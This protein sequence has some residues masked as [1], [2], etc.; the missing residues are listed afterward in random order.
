MSARILI[1][2]DEVLVLK[3]ISRSLEF[4]FDLTLAT[5]GLEALKLIRHQAAFEI[6]ISDLRMP[7]MDG[8]EFIRRA[9]QF[10]PESVFMLLT[11]NQDLAEAECAVDKGLVFR[12]MEKPCNKDSILESIHA[13]IARRASQAST[14]K[15]V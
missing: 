5:S 2:D 11:G 12:I 9:R 6:I 3:A 7:E 1:V 13:A 15:P 14:F 8:I 4:D 10:S